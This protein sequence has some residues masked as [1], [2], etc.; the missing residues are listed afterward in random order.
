[1][2]SVQLYTVG[3]R[4]QYEHNLYILYFTVFT[5]HIY[6][7]PIRKHPPTHASE[8]EIFILF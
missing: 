5:V 6:F 8:N 2:Y 1:M 4:L 3:V 7:S